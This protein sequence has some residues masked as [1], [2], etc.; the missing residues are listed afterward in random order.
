MPV[1]KSR[2]TLIFIHCSLS[3]P[4]VHS[5]PPCFNDLNVLT[6]AILITCC[7]EWRENTLAVAF[8]F[9]GR[10]KINLKR[11]RSSL[12][13]GALMLRTWGCVN[14]RIGVMENRVLGSRSL[15]DLQISLLYLDHLSNAT[16]PFNVAPLQS[17]GTMPQMPDLY[18]YAVNFDMLH[19]CAATSVFIL[20]F[21]MRPYWLINP[22]PATLQLGLLPPRHRTFAYILSRTFR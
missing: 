22:P 2:N 4:P 7:D 21:V 1:Y 11:L 12:L 19:H 18:R 13:I 17:G 9:P 16:S 10:A 8:K 5:N 15:F 6:N 20:S 3:E 14:C